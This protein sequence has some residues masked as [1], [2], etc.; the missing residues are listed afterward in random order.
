[1]E[2][3]FLTE[4]RQTSER[5]RGRTGVPSAPCPGREGWRRSGRRD[6]RCAGAARRTVLP[7]EATSGV[8]QRA[9]PALSSLLRPA[10]P[11]GSPC[12]FR[13][14]ASLAAQARL[15]RGSGG[16]SVGTGEARGKRRLTHEHRWEQDPLFSCG[17]SLPGLRSHQRPGANDAACPG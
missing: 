5:G 9:L 1:M 2:P 8:L 10:V 14:R 11:Q 15:H 17:S 7:A 6:R 4:K 3:S 13:R 12:H 16:A